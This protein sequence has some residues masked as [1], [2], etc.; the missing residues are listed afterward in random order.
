[1]R[2]REKERERET[3][4]KSVIERAGNEKRMSANLLEIKL[5]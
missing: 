3:R 5:Y 1:M 4:G 2:E